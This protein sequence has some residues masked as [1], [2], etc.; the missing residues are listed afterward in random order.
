MPS[1]APPSKATEISRLQQKGILEPLNRTDCPAAVTALS[2]IALSVY[3]PI[4]GDRPRIGSR[5]HTM[6]ARY[7]GLECAPLPLLH[8]DVNSNLL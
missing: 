7:L 2:F 6:P 3:R 4:R 5:L 8:G 1:P